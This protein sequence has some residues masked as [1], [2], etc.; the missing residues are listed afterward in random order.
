MRGPSATLQGS[1]S[2]AGWRHMSSPPWV[3]VARVHGLVQ[4]LPREI[5]S[6]RSWSGSIGVLSPY[7]A[8]LAFSGSS[9]LYR[10]FEPFQTFSVAEQKQSF[11]CVCVLPF[12]LSF[13]TVAKGWEKIELWCPKKKNLQFPL[14]CEEERSGG[15][16][17]IRQLEIDD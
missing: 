6:V 10:E 14:Q 2:R 11:L 1:A 17:V 16:G 13:V 15:G 4:R 8:S 3:N 9:V 5:P 12:T 7:L